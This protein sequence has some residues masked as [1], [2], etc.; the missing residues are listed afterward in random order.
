MA[1]TIRLLKQGDEA[2]L[3]N[4]AEDVFDEVVRAEL[5]G[6]F[7]ADP[8]HHIVVAL[9]GDLVVGMV[10]AVDYW[11]PDKPH[12][13][14]INETGVDARWQRRGIAKAMMNMM[15][16]HG[17]SLGCTTAWLGTERSNIA[18]VGLYTSLGGTEPEPDPVFFEFDLT[19]APR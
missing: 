15:F 6:A 8:R 12:E 1:I 16:D 19:A 7:L 18:A 9:D 2:V 10:S 3:G 11:H 17:R 4:V 14:F 13:F 5:V